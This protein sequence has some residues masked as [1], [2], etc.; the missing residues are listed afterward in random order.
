MAKL[1]SICGGQTPQ[2]LV[3]LAE[4]R[5]WPFLVARLLS[6]SEVSALWAQ[7]IARST[8]EL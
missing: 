5:L 8:T 3:V 7:L 6:I 4:L 1:T 2:K